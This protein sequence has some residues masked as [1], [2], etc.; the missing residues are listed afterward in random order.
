MGSLEKEKLKIEKVKALIEQL[1]V[2]VALIIGIGGGVG[3]LIVYFERFK[4]KELVLT[5]IG[6]G[7]FVLALILFMA[8]NLWSKIEQ[9]KKGW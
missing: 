8:G 5:L 7:I 3:S 4:N 2:L 1:K 9:L 6:T